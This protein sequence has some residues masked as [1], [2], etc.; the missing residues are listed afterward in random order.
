VAGGTWQLFSSGSLRIEQPGLSTLNRLGPERARS[1]AHF[2]LQ[3][4]TG[5]LSTSIMMIAEARTG[6]REDPTRTFDS[7]PAG[8]GVSTTQ[9]GTD[10]AHWQWIQSMMHA[11]VPRRPR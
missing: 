5:S 1:K 9:A 11:E 7:E 4:C 8:G 2:K 3:A 10:G 6:A